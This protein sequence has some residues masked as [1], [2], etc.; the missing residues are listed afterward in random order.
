MPL[1]Q[2]SKVSGLVSVPAALEC[3]RRHIQAGNLPAEPPYTEKYLFDFLQP[4]SIPEASLRFVL[5]QE[6]STCCVGMR[7]TERVTQNLRALEGP[8]L[9]MEQLNR[10]NELFS[11]IQMQVR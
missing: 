5:A 11:R 4:F 1:N 2:A 8:S 6:I 10:I 9:T 3:V 7:T